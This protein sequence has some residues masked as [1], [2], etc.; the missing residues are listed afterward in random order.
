MVNAISQLP[1]TSTAYAL[2]VCHFVLSN[3]NRNK[4]KIKNKRLNAG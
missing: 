2:V 3:R 4:H 1:N